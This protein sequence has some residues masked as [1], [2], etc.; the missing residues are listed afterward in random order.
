VGGS[1]SG[2]V[3]VAVDGWQWMGGGGWVA[4]RKWQNGSG[5]GKMVV[6]VDGWQVAVWQCD[7]V[8]VSV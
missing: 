3:G 7:R 5:S 2:W 4:K 8:A 1:G 6:A